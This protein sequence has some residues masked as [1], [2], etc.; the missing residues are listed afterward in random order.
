MKFIP[1]F[2]IVLHK[3]SL[4]AFLYDGEISLY[5]RIFPSFVE[6]KIRSCQKLHIRCDILM[7]FLLYKNIL[8]LQA[9]VLAQR[10]YDIGDGVVK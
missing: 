8:L 1:E 4:R 9:V 7:E 10:L 2:G 6:L 3:T 5:L